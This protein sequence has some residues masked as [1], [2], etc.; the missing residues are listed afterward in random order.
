MNFLKAHWVLGVISGL[1]LIF[2]NL[3]FTHYDPIFLEIYWTG[4]SEEKVELQVD[5][6]EGFTSYEIT[7][8][9]LK[10]SQMAPGDL[11]KL[12]FNLPQQRLEQVKVILPS[13]ESGFNISRVDLVVAKNSRTLPLQI[14]ERTQVWSG[15][16][17]PHRS[18]HPLILFI[19]LFMISILWVSTLAF[20]DW[21]APYRSR[22]A[23]AVRHF[24]FCEDHRK[25]FWGCFVFFSVCYVSW[26]LAFWPVAMSNDSWSTFCD[27]LSLKLSDWHP[28][29]YTLYTLAL[30]QFGFGLGALGIFQ[31]I[32]TAAAFAFVFLFCVRNR[33]KL[34]YLMPFILFAG[35]SI[36][37]GLFTHTMWKDVP[38]SIAILIGS[39]WL[40][41]AQWQVQIQKKTIE[42]SWKHLFGLFILFV[43]LCT[44]RKNGLVYYG[45]FPLL[46]IGT[47]NLKN[48]LKMLG[49]LVLVMV[50][51]HIIGVRLLDVTKTNGSPYHQMHTTLGMMTHYN[52]YSEN[53]ARDFKIME[54]ATGL[55]WEEITQL[56]PAHWYVL[57]DKTLVNHNQWTPSG[58]ET[59]DYNKKFIFRLMNENL[60]IFIAHKTYG[61]FHSMGIDAPFSTE[62]NN[63]YEDPLQLQGSGVNPPG[64]YQWGATVHAQSYLPGLRVELEKI[65]DWSFQFA[66]LAS[67]MVFIWNLLFVLGLFLLVIFFDKGTS[68]VGRLVTLHLASAASVFVAGAGESWRYFYDIYLTGI[69]LIPLY[70]C[71][72]KNKPRPLA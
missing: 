31:A 34:K 37:V 6:G 20:Q 3:R 40:F 35:F 68:P 41:W 22:G 23:K 15:L 12:T 45:V 51:V 47:L 28:Y 8:Q 26:C 14:G 54:D 29:T 65:R 67:P 48:Y 59:N 25:V 72:L 4:T 36:P 49:V 53:R 19:Q 27:A 39:L 57:W 52:F 24:V 9:E 32:A 33:I 50:S 42:L 38:F 62:K 18:W 2:F 55:K 70:I 44:L 30:L 56:F 64:R 61:F 43:G 66:G 69:I 7:N 46:A 71:Y 60:P 16:N 21:I 13:T 10:N 1:L 58:G 17:S 11:K 63:F 5:T